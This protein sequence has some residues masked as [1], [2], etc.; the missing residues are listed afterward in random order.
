[1]NYIL[2]MTEGNTELALLNVLLEKG[3]L[4]FSTEELLM[5]KIYHSRQ[6]DGEI[7]GYIQQVDYKDKVFIYRVGDKLSDKLTIPSSILPE[8]IGGVIN[9]ST[10]PEFEV[11]F[12]LNEDLYDEFLKV[13]STVKASEFY[14]MHHKGYN[15]QSKFVTNYFDAMTNEEIISLIDLYSRKHGKTI[16]KHQK[17]LKEIIKY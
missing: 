10:I 4:K 8:K 13:K 6:I 14:K 7:K 9:I 2:I 11:L 16:K 15:K 17:T 1:M 12:L 3:I 5:E